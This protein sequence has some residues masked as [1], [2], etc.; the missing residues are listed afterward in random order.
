MFPSHDPRGGDGGNSVTIM[1]A[2]AGYITY[3]GHLKVDSILVKSGQE[4][5]QGDQIGLI[6]N[7]GYSTGPHL[8]F[9]LN[10]GVSETRAGGTPVDPVPFILTE[11]K[12]PA[13]TT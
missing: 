7:T 6:G 2:E 8:H 13:T 3:Y 5:K 4:V 9:Q 10:Q 12:C 1:H 11:T